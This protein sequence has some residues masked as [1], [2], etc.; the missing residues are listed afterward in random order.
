MARKSSVKLAGEL[1]GEAGDVGGADGGGG[2]GVVA[3]AAL[4]PPGSTA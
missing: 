4:L 3:A 1:A 2:G